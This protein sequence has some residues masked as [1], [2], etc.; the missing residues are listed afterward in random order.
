MSRRRRQRGA[1]LVTIMVVTAISMLIVSMLVNHL[2]LQEALTI[3]QH[4]AETRVHWAKVG[5]M[6]YILSRAWRNHNVLCGAGGTCDGDP[7][8]DDDGPRRTALEALA[9]ELQTQGGTTRRWLYGEYA[10]NTY[11]VDVSTTVT[12]ANAAV[13]DGRMR[14]LLTMTGVGAFD[15]LK[16]LK[17]A[18]LWVDICLVDGAA[19]CPAGLSSNEAYGQ[20]L[21]T[22]I[23]RVPPS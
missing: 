5:H 10:G 2:A 12:D 3:E 14:F 20:S 7:S 19:A 13:V 9:I 6:N 11:Y 4:L 23:T 1:V 22:R 17:V 16:G 18:N 8:P 21:I 15:A